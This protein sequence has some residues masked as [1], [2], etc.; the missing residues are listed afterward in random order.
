MSPLGKLTKD[1]MVNVDNF[2]EYDET[3]QPYD[4]MV[5]PFSYFYVG[6]AGQIEFGDFLELDGLS[7]KYAF[8]AGDDWQLANGQEEGFGQFAFKAGSSSENGQ[9]KIV[10]NL[11]YEVQFRS[12]N[13]AGWP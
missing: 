11:P 12:M 10:W 3:N 5:Q 7:I 8:V 2:Y 6:V 13:P 4:P 1:E 9:R